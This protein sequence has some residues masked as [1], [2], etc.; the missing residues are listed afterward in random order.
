MTS[1]TGTLYRSSWA[2]LITSLSLNL[3]QDGQ[4]ILILKTIAK[5]SNNQG[6]KNVADNCAAQSDYWL[7]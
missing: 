1:P 2:C 3:V 6:F 7:Q 5:Q 4:S